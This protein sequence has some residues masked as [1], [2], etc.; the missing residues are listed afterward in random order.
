VRPGPVAVA[1][2]W[3]RHVTEC[4]TASA[5][6]LQRRSL[7]SHTARTAPIDLI[8]FFATAEIWSTRLHSESLAGLC[9]NQWLLS[10]GSRY[11]M[12]RS[13]NHSTR[14]G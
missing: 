13:A 8:F 9:R 1:G 3:E 7:T 5:R 14:D 10:A 12:R 6:Y 4:A 2:T 11:L